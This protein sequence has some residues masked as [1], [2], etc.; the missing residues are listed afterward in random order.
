MLLGRTLISKVLLNC[1]VQIKNSFH[2]NNMAINFRTSEKNRF[3]RLP[4]RRC[5]IRR[6]TGC[7]L[8]TLTVTTVVLVLTLSYL[9]MRLMRLTV[10]S[11]KELAWLWQ[12]FKSC[13]YIFPADN[14]LTRKRR[15]NGG[16]SRSNH[17]RG[18]L[19]IFRRNTVV[20]CPIFTIF[21]TYLHAF[22]LR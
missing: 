20:S 18:G 5:I 9:K 6:K 14:C 21:H 8:W 3:R 22:V 19:M 10:E 12:N 15:E 4:R 16:K 2:F 7:C 11:F 1:F 13:C 17:Y